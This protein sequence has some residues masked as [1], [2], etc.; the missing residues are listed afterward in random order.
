MQNIDANIKIEHIKSIA[1][2]DKLAISDKL[3]DLFR[4]FNISALCYKNKMIKFKG[5]S[6]SDI[7]SVLTLFPFMAISTVNSFML[8]RFKQLIDAQ[9]D[10]FFRLKNNEEYNWRNL[11]YLFAKRFNKLNARHNDR[12]ADQSSENPQCLIVDDSLIPKSGR[13]IEFI[14]KVFDHVTKDWVLGFKFLL[15]AF[16]DGNSLIPLDF[17]YHAEKGKNKKYPFGLLKRQLN[18]RFTKPRSKDTAGYRRAQEVFVDKIT[19]AIALIKRAVKHGFVPDYV[20]SDSWFSTKKLIKAVRQLKQGIIHF[21]GM[22]KMDQRLYDYQGQQ[23]NAKELIK[24]LKPTLMKR[25]K[26]LNAYYIEVMV[27]YND[28]GPVK[29]FLT[30]FSKRSKWRLILA[31]DL[32]LSFQQAMK[33]Y[34]IRWTIEVMFKEC[35]Q[36]LN[37]GKCQSN[38]FDAQIADTTISLLV[39]MMLSFHKKIHSYTTLGALFAQYRDDFIE[40]TVAEKLWQLFITLQFTIAEILEIDCTKMMRV[41]FQLPEVNNMFKS[42]AKLLLEDNCSIA[43]KKAA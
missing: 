23:L 6:V 12:A 21:L 38:D 35:K 7:I 42:L 43:F 34:N 4:M 30:R 29:L 14:G 3:I 17:S 27:N 22:V 8:S 9:K 2:K 28:I 37:L 33:I 32:N 20:L 26:K 13:K 16:W 18:Q 15:L 36:H 40:A 11:T 25:A 31:T 39:Y 41:I 5:Y 19:T 1:T 24:K 10:A